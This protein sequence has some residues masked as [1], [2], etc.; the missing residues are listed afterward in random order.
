MPKQFKHQKKRRGSKTRGTRKDQQ[1]DRALKKLREQ[2]R[3]ETKYTDTNIAGGS[4]IPIIKAG[5]AVS[6]NYMAQGDQPYNRNGNEIRNFMVDLQGYITLD[7]SDATDRLIKMALVWDRTPNGAYPTISGV[8]TTGT[9]AVYDST[10]AGAL[11][12]PMFYPQSQETRARFKVIY[13]KVITL[14]VTAGSGNFAAPG[15]AAISKPFRIRKRLSRVSK[16]IAT[17]AAVTSIMSNSL[18]F[19]TW[20]DNVGTSSPILNFNS[21]VYFTDV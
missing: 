3:P 5:S 6:L 2:M 13:S 7:A 18:L 20:T 1:Q 8:T 17:T 15:F 12:P 9:V 19:I 14:K 10:S 21:R 16:F 4:G 11:I